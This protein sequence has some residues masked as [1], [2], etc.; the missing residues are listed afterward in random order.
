MLV[1]DFIS[2][3]SICKKKKKKVIA[4]RPDKKIAPVPVLIV[5]FSKLAE[6]DE[7]KKEVK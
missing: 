7:K 6:G 4:L 2:E 5:M 1:G 3:S